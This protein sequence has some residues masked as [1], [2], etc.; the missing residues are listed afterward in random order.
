MIVLCLAGAAQAELWQAACVSVLDGDS[1]VVMHAGVKKEIRLYGIDAPEFDQSFGKQAR[2]CARA[3][4]FNKKVAVEPI[5]TDKYGRTVAKVHI[6]GDCLNELL[7]ARGC[8]WVYTRYCRPAEKPAWEA[9]EQDARQQALGLWAQP[10]PIPPWDFRAG[11]LAAEKKQPK[12]IKP[13][14]GYYRGNTGSLVFHAPGCPYYSCKNCTAGFNSI[15]QAMR[16]GYT[17]CKKCIDN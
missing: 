9:L 5:E 12:K 3:L 15:G 6:A 11:K 17:P 2:L 1:L 16:A 13:V 10:D 8:A 4:A 14:T 7:I